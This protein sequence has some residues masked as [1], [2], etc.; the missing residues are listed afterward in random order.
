MEKFKERL[1]DLFSNNL[2]IYCIPYVGHYA[3]YWRRP[4]VN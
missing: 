2:L 3:E 4:D 1:D